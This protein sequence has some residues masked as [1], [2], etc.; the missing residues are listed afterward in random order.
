MTSLEPAT[1]PPTPQFCSREQKKHNALLVCYPYFKSFSLESKESDF[2]STDGTRKLF[3]NGTDTKIGSEKWKTATAKIL[4]PLRST[5]FVRMEDRVR[6]TLNN[7]S[8][9]FSSFL[10]TLGVLQLIQNRCFFFLWHPQHAEFSGPTA[11]TTPNPKQLGH[12]GTSKQRHF[13]CLWSFDLFLG[14]FIVFL[15]F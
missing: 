10:S 15:F 5:D 6:G 2:G 4:I 12:Q 3:L 14:H 11:M 7:S 13:W 8:L 9:T 1:L